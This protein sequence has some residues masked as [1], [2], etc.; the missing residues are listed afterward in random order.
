IPEKLV[1]SIGNFLKQSHKGKIEH[2]EAVSKELKTQYDLLQ[3]RIE[4]MYEDK[5]DGSIT[6]DDYNKRLL[7][8]RAEQT[9]IQTRLKNLQEVDKDYYSTGI[10][11]L[12]LA[13]KAPAI[14]KSSEPDVKRQLVKLILQN[15]TINDATLTATIRKPFSIFAKGL[16]RSTWLPPEDSNFRPGGYKRPEI[17][18]GLGLY[19]CLWLLTSRQQVH[20]L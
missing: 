11:L 3:N 12:K 18:F 5:L 6:E 1:E 17:T 2:Y 9:N 4:K 16:S 19:H 20:S 15:P 10:Y 13:N 8:Y 14:F 7:K